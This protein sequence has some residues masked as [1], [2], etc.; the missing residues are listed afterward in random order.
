MNVEAAYFLIGLV[1]GFVTAWF[2]YVRSSKHLQLA[3]NT[4]GSA[5]QNEF[6]NTDFKRDKK[7]NIT[8]LNVTVG[9]QP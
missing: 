8:G 6:E 7:G 3:V 4:L 5:F 1:L 9:G 2:F